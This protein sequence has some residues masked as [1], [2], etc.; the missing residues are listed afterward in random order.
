MKIETTFG[1]KY[2]FLVCTQT[3][4]EGFIPQ[5]HVYMMVNEVQVKNQCLQVGS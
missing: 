2:V 5:K 1:K 3:L 4:V